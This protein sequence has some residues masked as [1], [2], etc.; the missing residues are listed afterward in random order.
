MGAMTIT[1]PTTCDYSVIVPTQYVCDSYINKSVE[2]GL[3]G[4]AVF[5]II[6]LVFIIFYCVC[7]YG[8]NKYRR[9]MEGVSAVPQVQF[10]TTVFPFWVKTGCMVSWAF[11]VNIFMGIRARI[12]GNN[13]GNR[14]RT[15]TDAEGKYEDLD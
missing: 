9:G 5:L 14:G 1:E 15:D 7:G 4:G 11:T 12:T 3:S 10:W 8:F 13:P 2:D 6:L